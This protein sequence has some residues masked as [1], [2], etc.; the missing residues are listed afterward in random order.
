MALPEAEVAA[1]SELIVATLKELLRELNPQT[2]H[3]Y[4]PIAGLHEVDVG[5]LVEWLED[6]HA[7]IYASRYIND[8]WQVVSRDGRTP[9]HPVRF[10]CV[11]M[12]MLGFDRRLHRLGHGGGYYD[13]LLSEQPQAFKLGVCFELG[14][15]P[16]I[17]DEP[18]DV[19]MDVVTTEAAIYS[20]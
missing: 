6:R 1:K 14:K 16:H 11:I 4:E 20:V 2:A 9:E 7:D 18:H 17:P 5:P 3:C 8:S 10:D 15:L 13:R 19:V 12:P